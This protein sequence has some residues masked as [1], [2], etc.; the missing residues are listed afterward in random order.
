MKKGCYNKLMEW[1][2]IHEM[3]TTDGNTWVCLDCGRQIRFFPEFEVVNRGDQ[4]VRHFG[5]AGGLQIGVGVSQTPDSEPLKPQ[6]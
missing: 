4:S 3:K 5:S 1:I 6:F 2:E